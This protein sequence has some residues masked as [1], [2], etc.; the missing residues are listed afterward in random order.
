MKRMNP[1]VHVCEAEQQHTTFL[2]LMGKTY[3][4][5]CVELH[6]YAWPLDTTT[7]LPRYE[8]LLLSFPPKE[9][10]QVSALQHAI[11]LCS[12]RAIPVVLTECGQFV[13]PMPVLDLHVNISLDE[14][15]LVASQLIEWIDNNVPL[16][17]KYLFD[18]APFRSGHGL[19][20][21]SAAS[22][23]SVDNAMIVR[24]GAQF[25][26]EPTGEAMA[27]MSRLGGAER[28]ASVIV[29]DPV[30]VPA[31]NKQVPVLE[32]VAATRAGEV[33]LAVVN[34]SPGAAVAADVDLGSQEHFSS[35]SASLLDGP[36]PTAYNTSAQPSTV[37]SKTTLFGSPKDNFDWTFLAHSLTLLELRAT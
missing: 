13:T 14:G 27:L 25:I 20:V 23:L 19:A 17:Q 2:E 37:A 30:V 36:S 34:T 6:E 33:Q 24:S 11:R 29:H 1:H 31:R 35:L 10:A 18:S 5:D 8:E 15:L 21:S 4:Y 12:G 22:G 9:G 32:A 28:L 7:S 26:V 16:A 3:P